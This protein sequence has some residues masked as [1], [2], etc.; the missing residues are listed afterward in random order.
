[1]KCGQEEDMRQ[2]P[3]TFIQASPPIPSKVISSWQQIMQTSVKIFMRTT[4]VNLMQ[5][6][7][8]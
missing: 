5:L 3:P 2:I 6:E 7:L 4:A 1:M 8:P